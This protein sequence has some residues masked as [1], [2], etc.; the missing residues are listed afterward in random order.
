MPGAIRR[1]EAL[2]ASEPDRYFLPQQFKNPA[3][4]RIHEEDT[5]PKSG[6][7][8]MQSRC[9]GVWRGHRRQPS[10]IS[11]YFE[12]V[13]KQPLLSVRSSGQEP[14]AHAATQRRAAQTRTAQDPGLGAGFIPD[15]LDLSMSIALSWSPTRNPSRPRVAFR[16]RRN[17][18]GDF[19]RC[20]RSR[21]NS[22]GQA[23]RICGQDHRG[24]SARL[25]RALS[26]DDL[27]RGNSIVMG[28]WAGSLCTRTAPPATPSLRSASPNFAPAATRHPARCARPSRDASLLAK[29]SRLRTR[30]HSR[31]RRLFDASWMQ[32]A[33]TSIAL[34][35]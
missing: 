2:A 11:R 31:H 25:R 17:P 32:T 24:H 16:V 20:R 34:R 30:C 9:P 7:I 12:K 13:K 1:A 8:P 35:T 33:T 3:N 26:L 29:A 18:F 19:V 23:R 27:V 21:G 28:T 6:T 10:G 5:G 22:L 4:P 15:T 14:R